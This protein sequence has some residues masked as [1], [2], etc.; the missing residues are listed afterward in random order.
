MKKGELVMILADKIIELRKKAGWSQEEL[1]EKLD[2]SRQSVSKWESAQSMPDMNRI[3]MLSEVFGVS[4]DYLLKDELG[5]DPQ[6][7][8]APPEDNETPLRRVSMEES[9]AFLSYREKIARYIPLGVA[10]CILS[11]IVLILLAAFSEAGRIALGEEAAA[12]IGLVVLMLM[13]GVAVALFV[14][15]GLTG[16]RFEY[17]SRESFETE[18]GV[19]GFVREK[20]EREQGSFVARLV[21]GIVLCVLSAV[22]IFVAMIFPAA[23]EDIAISSKNE[24]GITV[25]FTDAVSSLRFAVAVAVLL[26]LVAIGVWLIVRAALIR[27][28]CDILLEEGDY[29]RSKK[30]DQKRNETFSGVYWGIVT[31]G[32][33][34]YSFI[35]ADWARSWIVWPVAGV[36]F[37]VVAAIDGAVKKK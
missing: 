31:A 26:V 22:P 13:V 28:G 37:G 24:A 34:A 20:R 29:S 21:C 35:T 1:A 27:G 5:E 10:L 33:L 3:L 2:V 32:Y 4:T 25:A 15:S 14:V 30:A 12:G 9:Q 18:Y 8:E 6:R 19:A 16:K 17:L 23:G 36:L 7:G 11:P